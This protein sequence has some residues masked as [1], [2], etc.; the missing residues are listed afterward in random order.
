MKYCREKSI[1]NVMGSLV[2]MDTFSRCTKCA[3][4]LN[5]TNSASGCRK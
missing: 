5:L 3:V 1:S 2:V 4:E